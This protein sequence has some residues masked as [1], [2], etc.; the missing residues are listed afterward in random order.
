MAN[1]HLRR[2]PLL[3]ILNPNLEKFQSYTGQEPPDEYL[4]KVIQSWAHFEGHMTL[5]ENANAGDFDN[6]YKCEI[7]KS[8]MGGKYIPVPAN[9]GLIAGNPAI[10][11][12]DTLR[13]WMKAKY[14]RETV[15]NQQIRPLLL[16]VADNDAQVLG[17]LKSQLSGDL[18]T[19]MRI[20]NPASIDA[21]FTELKNLWLERPPNLN[22][23]QTSQN[24]SSAEIE[25]LNSQIAS[26]QAQLAQLA[27]VHPQNNEV[28]ANFEKLN[29]KIASLEA[30]LA[31]S[32]QVHSNLAQ[33]LQLPENVI[34]SNSASTFD[35]YINQELE[36]RLG[37]I[38]INLAKL[39][40]LDWK[41]D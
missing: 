41:K 18:Y 26:L 21:F 2:L 25:K 5:L 1:A 3:K 11:S 31:E 14:Q 10:N 19:W 17:F 15:E 7:L 28:S 34:N 23:I 37:V 30:Q 24:N 4:D 32:M 22:G 9:N 27:Q 35:R 33:R 39:T 29:S 12:P 20:A 6:A 36:K 40:K 38:K 13:A 8:M 16:G